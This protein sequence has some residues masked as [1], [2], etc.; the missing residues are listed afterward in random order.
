MQRTIQW[1]MLWEWFVAFPKAWADSLWIGR[2]LLLCWKPNLCDWFSFNAFMVKNDPALDCVTD[3]PDTCG[4]YSTCAIII[5]HEMTKEKSRKKEMYFSWLPDFLI[6]LVQRPSDLNSSKAHQLERSISG[7]HFKIV[8]AVWFKRTAHVDFDWE[9][10]FIG[11]VKPGKNVWGYII[12]FWM[13]L[14]INEVFKS[15]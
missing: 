2:S 14:L 8:F 15:L 3:H 7:Y 10:S 4:W 5:L 1:I 9:R 13:F 11:K 12:D 6:P